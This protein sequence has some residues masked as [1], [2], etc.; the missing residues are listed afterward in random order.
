MPISR[1][2]RAADLLAFGNE[3]D[4]QPAHYGR[5]VFFVVVLT[6]RTKWLVR[7][8]AYFLLELILLVFELELF[9]LF[10]RNPWELAS[11]V[12][13]CGL[14]SRIFFRKSGRFQA[15]SM[16][17]SVSDDSIYQQTG[18]SLVASFA[19]F[20]SSS[21]SLAIRKCYGIGSSNVFFRSVQNSQHM[22]SRYKA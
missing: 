17:V 22:R 14:S 7:N 11:K 10:Y 19:E 3:A 8:F 12:V 2:F 4:K 1:R 6:F 5:P 21:V 9:L 16:L 13:V 18:F 20:S 15:F